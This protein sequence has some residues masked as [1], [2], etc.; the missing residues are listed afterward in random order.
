M[1]SLRWLCSSRPLV[2]ET[3]SVMPPISC[4]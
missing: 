3:F 1:S 2:S 4:R